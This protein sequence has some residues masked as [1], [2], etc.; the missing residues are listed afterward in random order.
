MLPADPEF[1]GPLPSG[2]LM[3]LNRCWTVATLMFIA[4]WI[5]CTSAETG[6]SNRSEPQPE[7]TPMVV[8]QPVVKDTVT[9][10]QEPANPPVK[11][12]KAAPRLKSSQDT[13]KVASA[14]KNRTTP[15]T[16]LVKP[17]NATYTVQVGAYRQANNALRIQNTLKKKLTN[18]TIYNKFH[19]SDKLYRVSVGSLKERK[20]AAALRRTLMSSDSVL[21]RECWVTYL[22]R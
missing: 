11:K 7:P 3:P 14:R 20:D 15:A 2:P 12:T 4:V 21:Y 16:P 17:P 10:K 18:H 22:S 5:G 9:R 6:A 19:A 13:V 1:I 8:P